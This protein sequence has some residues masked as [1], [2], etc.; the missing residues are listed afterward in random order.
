MTHQ[1]WR[2][3]PWGRPRRSPDTRGRVYQRGHHHTRGQAERLDSAATSARSACAT[4]PMYRRS[5]SPSGPRASTW[6]GGGRMARPC[7]HA[8]LSVREFRNIQNFGRRISRNFCQSKPSAIHRNP[9]THSHA[10][11]SGKPEDFNCT[12]VTFMHENGPGIPLPEEIPA[13][14]GIVEHIP[15][16]MS[17]IGVLHLGERPPN[18]SSRCCG[19]PI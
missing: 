2:E 11:R 3:A 5:G 14:F 17:A 18:R 13:S 7:C 16:V 8:Q 6:G 19:K 12:A 15:N 4:S 1:H 9:T 10:I